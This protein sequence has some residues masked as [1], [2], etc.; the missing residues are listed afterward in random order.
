MIL[1]S[2][3]LCL[4]LCMPGCSWRSIKP[5]RNLANL[6]RQAEQLFAARAYLD[7]TTDDYHAH[8]QSLAEKIQTGLSRDD[9]MH[10]ALLNNSTLQAQFEELGISRS[11]LEQAGL[12]NNPQ[13]GALF[14]APQNGPSTLVSDIE[15]SL[16]ITLSDLWQVPLRRKVARDQLEITTHEV[17][18]AI[19]DTIVRARMAYDSCIAADAQY[20]LAQ[21]TAKHAQTV[22]DQIYHR[23]NFGFTSDLDTSL[24]DSMVNRWNLRVIETKRTRNN[25]Y[26]DLRLTLALPISKESLI[27]TDSLEHHPTKIPSLEELEQHAFKNRP[28]VHIA[29]MKVQQARNSV[30]L[31]KA[32][33][34]KFVQFGLFYERDNDGSKTFGPE[35]FIDLPLFDNNY[36]QIARTNYLVKQ[37]KRLL[38]LAQDTVKTEVQQTHENLVAA[39]QT[40]VT[41]QEIIP[42]HERAAAH[43]E[44]YATTKQLSVILFLQTQVALY[45]AQQELLDAHLHVLHAVTQL[46]RAVGK[47]L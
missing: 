27:L 40:I 32:N 21:H 9:A 42:A 10:H 26:R 11:D 15:I 13:L 1:L 23:Q 37:Q 28:E 47:K 29:H 8:K 30:R 38:K 31:E 33:A 18:Q 20:A 16:S 25:A 43:A 35:V 36:A 41:Y 4:L 22:R 5:T 34:L 46:E 19:L 14:A 3:L 39:Q 6:E 45:E 7:K 12:F 17:L 2:T 24:A 44:K